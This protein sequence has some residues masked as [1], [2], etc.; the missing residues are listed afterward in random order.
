MKRF[1]AVV[2]ALALAAF[3]LVGC[4]KAKEISSSTDMEYVKEKGT[5][6]VGITSFEP[7]D[8]Q[9]ESGKWIGFDADMARAFAE[10]LGVEAKFQLIEWDNKVFELKDKNIDVAWNGMTLTDD[11]LAEMECSSPYCSNAQVVVVKAA[12]R[13]KYTTEESVKGLTFAV[14]AGSAGKDAAAAL[15]AKCNEV[16]SQAVALMEVQSGNSDAAV[17]DL[18]MAG[19]MIGE[20]TAY[21][22]LC[23][24]VR[25]TEEQYGVGFRKG[26]DL[27]EELNKFLKA[28]YDDG[29]LA[30]CA[31]KYNLTDALL[32][33]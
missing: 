6:I 28:A 12:D 14:E 33:Q 8:Y 30:E 17:I 9:D 13:E 27:A 26:S 32:E 19:A 7:M 20:G 2:L 25:L 11:V 22:D 1:L 21:P 29:T 5:L 31:E 24:T 23:Y 10:Y 15:G 3:G 16:E 18:L 4:G